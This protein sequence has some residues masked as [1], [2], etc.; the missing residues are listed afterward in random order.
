[1][2]EKPKVLVLCFLQE[3]VVRTSVVEKEFQD[4][5]VDGN[6]WM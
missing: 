4:D 5:N 2:Y 1:M 3:D 6:G